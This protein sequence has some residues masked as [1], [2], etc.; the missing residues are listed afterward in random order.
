M[1]AAHIP[2]NA[3]FKTWKQCKLKKKYYFGPKR[4]ARYAGI[5]AKPPKMKKTLGLKNI[6][7][8]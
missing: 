2:Q 1:N 8:H 5:V 7:S 4:S 3:C 6:V